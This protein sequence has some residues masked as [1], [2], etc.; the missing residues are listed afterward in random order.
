MYLSEIKVHLRVDH[1]FEDA[2]IETYMRWAEDE[3]KDSVSTSIYRNEA[4][5]K[6]NSHFERAVVLLVAYYFENRVAYSEKVMHNAPDAVL[7]AVQK[8]R[9]GYVPSEE[10]LHAEAIRET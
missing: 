3:V 7:S 6:D 9:G 4:Y 1:S 2:L 8:L 5:F 10:E